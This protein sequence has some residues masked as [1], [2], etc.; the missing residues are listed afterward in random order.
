MYTLIKANLMMKSYEFIL[1]NSNIFWIENEDGIYKGEVKIVHTTEGKT[2]KIRH[3]LG[4]M[5]YHAGNVY[6]G[7]WKDDLKWGS[8]VEKYVFT[9]I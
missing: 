7:E 1:K 8:G 5:I 2:I 4:V 6:E 9:V 3:G